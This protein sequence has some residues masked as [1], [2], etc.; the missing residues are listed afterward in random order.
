MDDI[1]NIFKNK[2]KTK[3][4]KKPFYKWQDEALEACEYLGANTPR[5]KGSIF[6]T[7]KKD[8]H[9]ARTALTDC[10]ELGKPYPLYYL[11]VFNEIRKKQCSN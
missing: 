3:E 4:K 7:F 8:P 5:F 2:S 9:T 11:K 6:Q 10:K 1:K